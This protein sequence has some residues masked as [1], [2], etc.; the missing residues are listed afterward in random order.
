MVNVKGLC[1]MCD[2]V[3]D[4]TV[5]GG[6]CHIY[7]HKRFREGDL[8]SVFRQDARWRKIRGMRS[9]GQK[10]GKKRS[11]VG[12]ES[13]EKDAQLIVDGGCGK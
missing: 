12:N 7:G 5:K 11:T 2:V 6:V 1:G 8:H 10:I 4:P 3:F 13:E 9:E